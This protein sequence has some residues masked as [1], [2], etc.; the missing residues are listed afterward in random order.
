MK[1]AELNYEQDQLSRLADA[2]VYAIKVQARENVGMFGNKETKWLNLSK[3][4][5]S[6]LIDLF[7]DESD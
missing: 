1:E 7:A 6:L 4:Q 2:D 3:R 5:L